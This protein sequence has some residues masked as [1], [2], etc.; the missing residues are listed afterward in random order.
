M[1]SEKHTMDTTYLVKKAEVLARL[2][3]DENLLHEIVQMYFE[4]CPGLVKQIERAIN[5]K[6][7]TALTRAAHD[8]KG[9]LSNFS[10]PRATAAIQALEQTGKHNQMDEAIARLDLLHHELSRLS[11]VLNSWVACN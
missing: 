5:D 2:N 1:N 4:D 8:L 10:S 7:S 6:N 9:L 11:S 3:G